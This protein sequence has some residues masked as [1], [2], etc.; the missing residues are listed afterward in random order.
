MGSMDPEGSPG[1]WKLI[2]VSM[3]KTWQRHPG[4][5]LKMIISWLPILQNPGLELI[6]QGNGV[7][8]P[9]GIPYSKQNKDQRITLD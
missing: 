5:G 3:A 7:T 8:D 1:I 2:K 9:G 4:S 6:M